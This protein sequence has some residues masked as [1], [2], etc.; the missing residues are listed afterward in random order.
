MLLDSLSIPIVFFTIYLAY[1]YADARN[2]SSCL[3]CGH[4]E[5]SNK[6]YVLSTTVDRAVVDILKM[7]AARVAY[8]IKE[9]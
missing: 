8:S 6:C 1:L 9:Q 5:I 2:R 4:M 7:K 3:V